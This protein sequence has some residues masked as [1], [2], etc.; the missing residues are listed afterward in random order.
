MADKLRGSRVA[1]EIAP[2]AGFAPRPFWVPMPSL[3]VQFRIL[4]I[5]DR[6]PASR[7]NPLN[8]RCGEDFVGGGERNA[9]N[10]GAEGFRGTKGVR[11]MVRSDVN[12]NGLCS[13]DWHAPQEDQ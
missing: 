3:D 2:I 4:T 8:H 11:G 9:V 1:D 5:C 10:A 12:A 7:E 13:R 6:L